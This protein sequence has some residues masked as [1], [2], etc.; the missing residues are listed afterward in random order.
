MGD[1]LR[2][3][4]WIDDRLVIDELL[5]V[6]QATDAGD[7]HARMAEAAQVHG[8]RW[9]MQIVDPDDNDLVVVEAK[10]GPRPSLN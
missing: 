7:R 2:V 1:K 3:K 9:R 6:D 4:L 10:S 5:G 8:K